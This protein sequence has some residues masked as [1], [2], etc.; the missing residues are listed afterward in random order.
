MFNLENFVSLYDLA[1]DECAYKHNST[2]ENVYMEALSLR[3]NLAKE[4]REAFPNSVASAK[5][6]AQFDC[7]LFY[8]TIKEHPELIVKDRFDAFVVDVEKTLDDGFYI[9]EW[10]SVI[11]H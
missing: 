7:A 9:P 5:R 4:F 10:I 1:N 8:K 3:D 11:K 2:E 6:I